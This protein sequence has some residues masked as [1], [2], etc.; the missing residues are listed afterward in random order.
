MSPVGDQLELGLDD[1]RAE[2]VQRP[3]GGQS[4]RALTACYKR[5]TLKAQAAKS[6]SDFVSDERQYDLWLPM[7]KS[8]FV[9]EG[10]S[11]L[12]PFARG[13]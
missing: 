10:A 2:L 13:E 1:V 4:P 6:V 12:V 11:L 7:K 8:P 3:W 5:F 9:Y